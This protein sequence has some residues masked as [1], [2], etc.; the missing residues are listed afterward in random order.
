M[1][2]TYVVKQS[3]CM[4]IFY[5]HC[6]VYPCHNKFPS[7]LGKAEAGGGAM[8]V[9]LCDYIMPWDMLSGTQKKGLSQRY[10]MGCECKVSWPG[11]DQQRLTECLTAG[12]TVSQTG[13]L[14]LLSL[15]FSSSSSSSSFYSTFFFFIVLLLVIIFLLFY[16]LSLPPLPL[17]LFPL[18]LYGLDVTTVFIFFTFL[19]F[20]IYICIWK[21]KYNLS[22]ALTFGGNI[23]LI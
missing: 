19:S 12:W 20:C 11:R 9:T 16:L 3:T 23:S 7:V 22:V 4:H 21:F 6:V 5:P 2:V 1:Y 8:Q 10:Q 17:F 14:C 13:P 18:L 15:S